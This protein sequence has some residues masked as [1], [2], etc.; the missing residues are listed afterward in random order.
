M[1]KLGAQDLGFLKMDTPRCPFHVAGLM[2]L[3]KPENAP[4]N[5][6]RGVVAKCGR[7]NE[8]WP[9]F[10]RKLRD[11]DDLSAAAW[12][13]DDDYIPERHVFH[14]ALPQPGRMQDLVTLATRA[15]ERPMDRS[16]PLWEVHVV[17]GLGRDRFAIYCKVHHA[18][19]DGVGAMKMLQ[20]MFSTSPRARLEFSPREDHHATSPNSSLLRQLGT[21]RKGLLRQYRA[22]PELSRLLAHMGAD[23]IG[24]RADAM[25]LPFTAPR[26]LFNNE[27]DSR[28]AIVLC[29]LPLGPVKSMAHQAGGSVND[30][31]L[32]ICGGALRAY[33]LE[34]KGLP[35]S[36]LVA[37]M[38]VSLKT[39]AAGAGNKLSYIMAPFFTNEADDLKRLQ[40]VVK[41]T[42]SAKEELSR[43]S[44][45]AAEDY[46]ALIM[47]P[48]ILLTLTGNATRV[49]PAINAIFSN[50]P[51]SR[52]KLYLEGAELESIYP[53]SIVTDAM[54]LN[55]T[56]L[57]HA[58]KLCI[59][60]ASCPRDQPEVE[61]LGPLLKQSYKALRTAM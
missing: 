24:G 31:L 36:S 59:A 40:R 55:I 19:M 43:I 4:R 11:P 7:L 46:Y 60:I 33:L 50:V 34:H 15:H 37:G 2:I 12:V 5:Y 13:E 32:A 8:L 49:R 51:G 30:V 42:S 47:A 54:G 44:T 35:R 27:L 48:T 39:G 41:V 61:S 9:V 14:Y 26:T 3:K 22:I 38:P 16:R 18:L 17:E 45:T 53:L 20:G 29:E 21:I 28:R 1:E 58:N 52:K 10:N 25:R 23:A 57:S 6:I 56:V